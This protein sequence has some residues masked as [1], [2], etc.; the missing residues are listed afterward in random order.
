[1][2]PTYRRISFE[3][4]NALTCVGPGRNGYIAHFKG[5]TAALQWCTYF[6]NYDYEHHIEAATVDQS[7]LVY[8]AGETASTTLPVMPSTFYSYY[9]PTIAVNDGVDNDGSIAM[10]KPVDDVMGW[11]T[12]FGGIAGNLPERIRTLVTKE[13]ALFAGGTTSK[14]TDLASSFPLQYNGIPGSFYDDI[15]GDL[16]TPTQDVFLT[17][18]CTPWSDLAADGEKSINPMDEG[19]ADLLRVWWADAMLHVRGVDENG[20]VQCFASDGRMVLAQRLMSGTHYGVQMLDVGSLAT[21]I[22]ILVTPSGD[23]SKFLVP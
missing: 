5:G 12:Y 18:F 15:L 8:I 21:G 4:P 19:S 6:G 14:F 22:Y 1:M 9:P 10:F 7:G 3:L 17:K 13:G 16:T 23:R 11:C 20:L 2:V